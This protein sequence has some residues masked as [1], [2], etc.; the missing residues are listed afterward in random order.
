MNK[1]LLIALIF[2]MF[3]YTKEAYAVFDFIAAIQSQVESVEKFYTKI[4]EG[5][6]KAIE[7]YTRLQ[8][9]FDTAMKCVKN[10]RSCAG[11]LA[12]IG[13]SI[14]NITTVFKKEGSNPFSE[15]SVQ[16]LD[17]Q[18]RKEIFVSGEDDISKI[19]ERDKKYN[20]V[21]IAEISTLWAKGVS[22]RQSI[23]K[24]EDNKIYKKFESSSS[25]E[26]TSMEDIL[27]AQNSLTLESAKRVNR[28]LE[29][30]SYM[31]SAPAILEMTIQNK[32]AGEN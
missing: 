7:K 13:N 6:K 31:I 11:Q 14:S 8:R 5:Y 22:T 9:G 10:P 19:S 1:K 18:A 15:T 3:L 23:M 27:F 20:N 16:D 29:L 32:S 17:S 24:E 2:S 21:V 12:G 25:G 4:M 30:R 26:N 28:I